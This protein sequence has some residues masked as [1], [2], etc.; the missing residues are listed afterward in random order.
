MKG[1]I[2][3]TLIGVEMSY[4]LFGMTFFVLSNVEADIIRL[5]ATDSRPYNGLSN[6]F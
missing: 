6:H 4:L 5:R 1:G 2:S 3:N